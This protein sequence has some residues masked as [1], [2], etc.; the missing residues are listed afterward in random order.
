ML[1]RQLPPESAL[2][3]EL[4]LERGS[5]PAAPGQ[6]PD[7]EVEQWSR[8]EHLLAAV[9]DELAALRHAFITANSKHKPRWKPEP[10]PRPGVK[11]KR[12]RPRLDEAQ[13]GAL[14]R[15]L[16]QMQIEAAPDN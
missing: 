1:I 15:Y 10:T 5:A 8:T 4:R 11:P 14:E 9:K 16:E 6:E 2:S 13:V 12:K 3:T 7:P